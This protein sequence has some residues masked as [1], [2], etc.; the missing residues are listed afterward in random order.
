[1]CRASRSRR[2]EREWTADR[3]MFR[4]AYRNFGDHE[5]LVVNHTIKGGELAGVRWYEIRSPGSSPSV[6][7]RGT[8]VDANTDF[9]LGS[10]GMDGAGNI[11]LGFS[12][13]SHDLDPSVFVVGRTPSD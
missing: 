11:A 13:S 4:L 6:F 10:I 8:V 9:W 7:Q 5:S 3:V 1:M 2:Q 12:A